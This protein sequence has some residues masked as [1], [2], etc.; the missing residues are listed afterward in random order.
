MVIRLQQYCLYSFLFASRLIFMLILK[1]IFLIFIWDAS[2]MD[3]TSFMSGCP[4]FTSG[5]VSM[6]LSWLCLV[7]VLCVVFITA[8]CISFCLS[9]CDFLRP[10]LCVIFCMSW[11]LVM[12]F[13]ILII[14]VISYISF[15]ILFGS[16]SCWVWIMVELLGFFHVFRS[17]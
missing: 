8:M 10:V 2:V 12:S 15:L 13:V 11:F 1:L 16:L 7:L 17:I 6:C 4:L 5:F 14:W 9:H 3:W